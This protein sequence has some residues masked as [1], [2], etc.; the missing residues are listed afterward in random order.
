MELA[1]RAF[2]ADIDC[3]HAGTGRTV[4]AE[5]AQGLEGVRRSFS[6]PFHAAVRAVAHP[7]GQPE[8]PGPLHQARPEED[9][10]HLAADAH[11]K[12]SHAG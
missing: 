11:V 2:L 12:A 9:P 8:L 1:G 4:L 6:D 10:L 7:A 5:C 3:R